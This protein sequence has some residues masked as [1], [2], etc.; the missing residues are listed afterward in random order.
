LFIGTGYEVI[1]AHRYIP[2][3]LFISGHIEKPQRFEINIPCGIEGQV[4]LPAVLPLEAATFSSVVVAG[5]S[6]YSELIPLYLGSYFNI[7]IEC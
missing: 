2:D 6:T 1:D 5:F 4:K 3:S 7:S